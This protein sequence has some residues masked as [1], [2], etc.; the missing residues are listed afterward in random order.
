MANYRTKRRRSGCLDVAVNAGKRGG[1]STKG[2]TANKNIKK[3]KKGELYYLPNFPEGFNQVALEDA[4]KDLVDE[5]QKR[6]PDEQLVKEKMDL[7]FALRRKEVVESEPA[8]CDMVEH[9]P[10]LFYRRSSKFMIKIMINPQK[11]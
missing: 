9:W 8:I 2:E 6:T 1:H 7:T 10:A 11:G 4:R 3:A 5:M